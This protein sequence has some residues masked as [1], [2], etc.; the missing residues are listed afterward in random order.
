MTGVPHLDLVAATMWRLDLYSDE[1]GID[2]TNVVDYIAL[3][4]TGIFILH[5]QC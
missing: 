5:I 3:I 2:D 1:R 4:H